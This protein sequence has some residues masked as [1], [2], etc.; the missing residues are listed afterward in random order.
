MGSEDEKD[1]ATAAAV[2]VK[3]PTFWAANP[4]AWF[5]QADAQLAL[6][7]V[8]CDQ[9]KYWYVVA[10][11]DQDTAARVVQFLEHPP[12]SN[13]Y[14]R[15]KDHLIKTFE[16]SDDERADRLLDIAELGDRR[17]SELAEEILRLNGQHGG[18][19]LLRRIFIRALPSALR[20]VLAASETQD[21][22]DLGLEADR[23]I[24]TTRRAN[25][26]ASIAAAAAAAADEHF[27]PSQDIDAIGSERRLCF[28]HK[29]FGSRATRCRAPCDWSSKPAGNARGGSRRGRR[30]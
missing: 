9:T 14:K 7:K 27:L 30:A 4:R 8:T 17:P 6:R 25:C 26:S 20:N 24:A 23:I 10:A 22:R 16:L 19:F 13:A 15:L 5:T 1:P 28:Y 11:L 12:T 21:L 18:H 3:L 29:Q 2:T